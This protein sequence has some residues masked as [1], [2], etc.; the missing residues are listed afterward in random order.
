MDNTGVVE[1]DAR[2]ILALNKG[3]D[4]DDVVPLPDA[5]TNTLDSE[6]ER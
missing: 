6:E 1:G 3:E 2:Q 5:G 4:I